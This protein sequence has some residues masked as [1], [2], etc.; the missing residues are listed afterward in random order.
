MPSLQGVDGRS[1]EQAVLGGTNKGRVGHLFQLLSVQLC[2]HTDTHNRPDVGAKLDCSDHNDV[3][4]PSKTRETLGKINCTSKPLTKYDKD[5]PNNATQ[6]KLEKPDF[7]FLRN[8]MGPYIESVARTHDHTID[9]F[10]NI[11]LDKAFVVSISHS[12]H[13]REV[14]FIIKR[15]SDHLAKEG[16][17]DKLPRMLVDRNLMTPPL[18]ELF[19][20]KLA[21]MV[22][23]TDNF[24]RLHAEGE[25]IGV[26]PE[27]QRGALTRKDTVALRGRGLTVMALKYN[28]PIVPAATA[29]AEVL[30]QNISDLAGRHIRPFIQRPLDFVKD[31]IFERF[32][33]PVV[34]GA[35][36]PSGPWPF[37]VLPPGQ[38]FANKVHTQ[39]GKPICPKAIVSEYNNFN[40]T[41]LT[42]EQVGN[43]YEQKIKRVLGK[44]YRALAPSGEYHNDDT[45]R[46]R[47]VLMKVA[48]LPE[49]PS[50]N[51][52]LRL[53]PTTLLD[54]PPVRDKKARQKNIAHDY[55]DKQAYHQTQNLAEELAQALSDPRQPEVFH[56]F[57]IVEMINAHLVED[58]NDLL[59]TGNDIVRAQEKQPADARRRF[60]NNLVSLL[61]STHL[62]WLSHQLHSAIMPA[63]YSQRLHA[64]YGARVFFAL[65]RDALQGW[66]TLEGRAET[67]VSDSSKRHEKPD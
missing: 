5:V 56:S 50:F 53:L 51:K 60:T 63:Q 42:S 21:C 37:Y 57:K 44:C 8:T 19:G 59:H 54:V 3:R 7:R 40:G 1:T 39:V 17:G 45:E 26:C 62:W 36:T 15:I 10:N 22:A 4:L 16:C 11:P 58:M 66:W 27:G 28:I 38:A 35:V 9:G 12:L 14:S 18:N 2:N 20:K 29:G 34:L 24:A 61:S 41:K 43:L 32:S 25:S 30:H 64:V 49:Q 23:D 33:L 52:L 48:S 67:A 13:T 46:L 65:A 6:G 55:P 31:F 47:D